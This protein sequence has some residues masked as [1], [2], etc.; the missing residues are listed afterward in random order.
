MDHPVL[1]L[2]RGARLFALFILAQYLTSLYILALHLL[3]QTVLFDPQLF[4]L[5]LATAL[6][7]AAGFII[8]NFYDAEKDRINRPQKYLLYHHISLRTQLLLYFILNSLAQVATGFVSFKFLL[9]FI[10]FMAAIGLYSSSLKRFFWIINIITTGLVVF[11]FFA[12][13]LYFKNSQALIF[14]SCPLP[15]FSHSYSGHH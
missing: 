12:I 1:T 8:N 10:F 11:P 3:L 15:F 9:F 2:C 6:S 4:A 7:T 5:V 14:F 13:S